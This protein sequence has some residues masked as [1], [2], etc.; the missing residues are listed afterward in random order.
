MEIGKGLGLFKI[1]GISNNTPTKGIGAGKGLVKMPTARLTF[2]QNTDNVHM[3]SRTKNII[4]VAYPNE[5]K[6]LPRLY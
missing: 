5:R 1:V 2:K 6:M 3:F 4:N